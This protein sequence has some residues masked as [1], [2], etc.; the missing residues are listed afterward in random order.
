MSIKKP[1]TLTKFRL[2]NNVSTLI[3]W[4]AMLSLALLCI[5]CSREHDKSASVNTLPSVTYRLKWL[6]NASAAGDIWALKAGF[7][8][9]AGINVTVRE[10]GAEQDA[11]TEILM[12]R[13]MFGTASADQVIRAVTKG[14][15]IVVLA[16]IFQSNPLQWIYFANKTREIARPNDLKGLTVGIT[17]GGNDEAIFNAL[18]KK[19]GL[20]ENSVNLY[21][22]HY[23]YA[24]FWKHKVAL[25]PVYKNT[26]GI[27]L[28]EKMAKQGDKAGFFNPERY[29]IKF[30]ANSLIT[31]R[32]A[33][34]ENPLLVK[35][36]ASALIAAWRSAL[37]EKNIKR[38]AEAIHAYDTD[39]PVAII[40]RQL[41]S[42]RR[43]VM[44]PETGP[45]SIDT[46]A[47]QQ[48]ADIMFQQGLVTK[49]LDVREIIVSNA[50]SDALPQK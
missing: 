5:S 24:P 31:S 1:N 4:A 30:V 27:V 8:K 11:I 26:E 46:A 10:G 16:Q 9:K 43:F 15:D 38:T 32:R 25:W 29:G 44:P 48:T 37:D 21:A 22:V 17:F 36:F 12:G 18:M 3:L 47:W 13:A 50:L 35:K 6:F 19:Y 39:T 49:R 41:E 7:F 45:G 28:Q 34:K 40:I 20:T 33:W 14:A 42:T 23:D 2:H